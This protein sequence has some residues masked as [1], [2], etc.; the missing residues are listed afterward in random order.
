MDVGIFTERKEGD[1]MDAS[2]VNW[3]RL[4][5]AAA[6]LLVLSSFWPLLFAANCT[7]LSLHALSTY[8]LLPRTIHLYIYPYILTPFIDSSSSLF[9]SLLF[10]NN[11]I[12]FLSWKS[13]HFAFIGKIV[14]SFHSGLQFSTAVY[15][16]ICSKRNR[17]Q[18][19][20]SD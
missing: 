19:C 10:F 2:F 3:R 15:V 11:L 12:K 4:R 16:I 20:G 13:R 8:L 9:T 14:N 1:E 6:V 17:S 18:S 5:G 7:L